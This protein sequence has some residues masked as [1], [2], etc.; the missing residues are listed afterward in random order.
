VAAERR[1]LAKDLATAQ[2]EVD[3]AQRKLST[4]SFVERA[5]AP[6]VAKMRDRLTAAQAE[7]TRIEGRLSALPP[8]GP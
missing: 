5:P 4:P 7:I 3:T 6:V 2:A 8:A 1:R